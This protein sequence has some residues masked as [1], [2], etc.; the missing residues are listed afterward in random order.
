MLK[1]TGMVTGDHNVFALT[2]FNCLFACVCVDYRRVRGVNETKS[3]L[4]TY[5]YMMLNDMESME[6]K[7]SVTF[8]HFT[9]RPGVETLEIRTGHQ[10]NCTH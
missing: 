6:S 7:S 4:F 10:E 1:Q 2:G 9:S 5:S 8:L 3:E